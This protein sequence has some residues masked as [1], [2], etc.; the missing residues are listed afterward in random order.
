[1]AA[2]TVTHDSPESSLRRAHGLWELQGN[3]KYRS[4]FEILAS[5]L[6]VARNSS[7]DRYFLMKRS[8]VNY[9]QLKKY[10][11]A[12]TRIGFIEVEMRGR[13]IQ[14]CATE[15]GIAF[16]RQYYILLGMLADTYAIGDQAQW[17][18]QRACASIRKPQ[19]Q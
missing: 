14:Y 19:N 2:Y 9:T 4:Y 5:I 17:V 8:G 18:Y 7:G 11:D 1:M 13:R 3:K 12:L 10:L 15:K 16:L 6:D